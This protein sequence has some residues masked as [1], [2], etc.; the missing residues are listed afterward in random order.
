MKQTIPFMLLIAALL[1]CYTAC[2]TNTSETK[3][4]HNTS[5]NTSN[6][7]NSPTVEGTQSKNGITL[8]PVLDSPQFPE[9]KMLMNRLK[10]TNQ[11]PGR[12]VFDFE[13]ENYYLGQQ[14]P[15]ATQK[16]CANSKQGQ[17]I[18]HILNGEPYTAYYI[19]T[20]SKVLSEGHYIS[21]AFLSRSYHESVKNP[22]ATILHQ[23]NVGKPA[24]GDD[25]DLTGPLLFYSRPKGDYIG[26]ND[27]KRV[28]LDFYLVNTD[29][30]KDGNRVKASI[31]GTEFLLGK[32]VPYIMEGLPEGENTIKLELIDKNGKNI[33]GPYNI[34]ERKINL[35]KQ[36]PLPQKK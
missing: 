13:I 7:T 16:M 26:E 4:T 17:H 19:D 8:I 12:V 14:T 25:V 11:Q 10:G 1:S 23:F 20:A 28:M 3:N 27:I 31:N 21:M 33:P 5:D 18:H 15:D 2:S 29:L 36:E 30:E 6:A 34:V 22:D 24:N 35:Y 32:W 9:A